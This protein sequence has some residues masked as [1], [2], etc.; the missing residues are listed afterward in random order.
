MMG[1][2]RRPRNDRKVKSKTALPGS[3][4]EVLDNAGFAALGRRIVVGKPK[5][6]DVERQPTTAPQ[7]AESERRLDNRTTAPGW[8]APVI[9]F[10]AENLPGDPSVAW[11]HLFI[12][13]YEVGC[14]ALAELG[15]ARIVFGGATPLAV[16]EIPE[17]LPRWDDVATAV[18]WVAAQGN[19]LGYRH[20]AG[21]RGQ[22]NQRGCFRP[23]IRAS[24]GCGP[25]YLAPEAFAVFRSL[26]LVI[27]GRW[28]EAAETILWRDDPPEWAIDFTEDERFTQACISAAERLPKDIA[29]EIETI[30]LVT[31]DEVSERYALE[32]QNRPEP[33]T[34][35]EIR[36]LMES[37][38]R[39]DLDA[40]FC[41]RWR[42]Q[43]GWL[44]P[45]EVRRSL[46]LPYDPL[47]MGM[48]R[49]FAMRYLPHHPFLSK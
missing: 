10:L 32:V 16:P 44:P 22:P 20:F 7:F 14:E 4:G 11:E 23:N 26:G 5:N 41:R 29:A 47:A 35:G 3:L 12:T 33:R 36:V 28:T 31:D 38:H 2:A 15:Q 6:S 13:A 27:D 8:T 43:D 39:A 37:F 49:A 17:V 34:K 24:H 19:L 30:A 9:E 46:R 48:R 40:L 42:L 25:A 1:K 45:D 21:A 18:V